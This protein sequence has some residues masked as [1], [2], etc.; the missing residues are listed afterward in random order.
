MISNVGALHGPAALRPAP[1]PL[2]QLLVAVQ[3]GGDAL[4]AEQPAADRWL[5]FRSF[6]SG[7]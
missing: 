5:K 3:S 7:R 6:G 2:A 1:G 4:L